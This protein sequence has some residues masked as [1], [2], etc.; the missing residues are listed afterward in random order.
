MR[1]VAIAMPLIRAT[2]SWLPI[3]FDWV[4]LKRQPHAVK[5]RDGT[6]IGIRPGLGD[7]YAFVETFVLN[8]YERAL[9]RL[10]PG[11]TVVDIGAH[12]GCFAIAARRRVG[13][14]GYVIAVEPAQD[15]VLALQRN[16]E[17]NGF[18]NVEIVPAAVAAAPGRRHLTLS[19][20]SLF[21]SLYDEIDGRRTG[22]EHQLTD[23]ITLDQLFAS[24]HIGRCD[25]L[26]M[27]CEGAEHDIADSM[28]MERAAHIRAVIVETHAVGGKSLETF[29][30]SMQALGFAEHRR[31][32]YCYLTSRRGAVDP[33]QQSR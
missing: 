18:R 14:R 26:K 5:L 21:S 1:K 23:V 4:G 11:N 27:D 25:L 19:D 12:V 29:V 33:D 13:A 31:Q 17:R 15:C 2:P 10:R 24:F 16:I 30:H 22:R 8:V 3:L 9:D 28:T 20:N 32:A 6:T 7:Y